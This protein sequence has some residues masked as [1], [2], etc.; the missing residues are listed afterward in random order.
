M[1]DTLASMSVKAMSRRS[2][3]RDFCTGTPIASVTAQIVE[4]GWRRAWRKA[5]KEEAGAK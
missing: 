4:K 3:K 2:G 1:L 5:G